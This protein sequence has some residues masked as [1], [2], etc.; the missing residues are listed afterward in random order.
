MGRALRGISRLAEYNEQGTRKWN[1]CL[2][3]LVFLSTLSTYSERT[4]ARCM[5]MT[6]DSDYGSEDGGDDAYDFDEEYDVRVYL[7]SEV[8]R[9][10]TDTLGRL[11]SA[12]IRE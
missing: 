1:D 10:L 5:I 12:G 3:F 11:S 8:E 4:D 9:C 6:D 2:V 7:P